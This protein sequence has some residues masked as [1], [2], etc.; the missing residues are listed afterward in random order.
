MRLEEL[1]KAVERYTKGERSASYGGFDYLSDASDIA[2]AFL[3]TSP[4]DEASL[5]AVGFVEG[6]TAGLLF[7]DAVGP[8]R[9]LAFLFDSG[10]Q[11]HLDGRRLH[12]Q[13]QTIGDL[14]FVLHRAERAVTP[15]EESSER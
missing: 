14:C 13:P 8:N 1:S 5:R 12:P 6:D 10:I 9:F 11:I 7:S 2:D 4:I 3:N 15:S